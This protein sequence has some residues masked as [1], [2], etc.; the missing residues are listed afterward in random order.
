MA[1]MMAHAWYLRIPKLHGPFLSLIIEGFLMAGKLT[2]EELEQRLKELEK[3][4]IQG[5]GREVGPTCYQHLKKQR[6]N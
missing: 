1:L 4:S 2:D 5:N 3:R 6:D